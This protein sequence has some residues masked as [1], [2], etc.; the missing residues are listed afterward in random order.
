MDR[1]RVIRNFPVREPSRSVRLA[2]DRL[3]RRQVILKS[4]ADQPVI[5]YEAS[6]LTRCAS[7]HVVAC[8]D[9]L[10]SA[11]SATC[12][13]EYFCGSTLQD[14]LD[15]GGG[16]LESHKALT[17]AN[18]V[19]LALQDM[20]RAG[21]LYRDLHPGHISYVDRDRI[22]IFDLGLAVRL[23]DAGLVPNP[24]ASGTWETMAPEEFEVGAALGAPANVYSVASLI[25]RL[26]VG[27]YPL[28]YQCLVKDWRELSSEAQKIRQ[29]ELHRNAVPDFGPLPR[30]LRGAL[31]TALEKRPEDRFATV[32][33][34]RDALIKVG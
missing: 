21:V 33:R 19:L 12:V 9:L 32:D 27:R 31:R 18:G 28:A 5:E 23:P 1:Y 24:H 3:L 30:E 4:D 2:E 6:L 10:K 22:K 20:N 11:D 25:Y 8:Y 16:R 17:V 29:H 34:F 13:I 26:I 7:C 14:V 15:R